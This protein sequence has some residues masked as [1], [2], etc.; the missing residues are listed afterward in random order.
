M[1]PCPTASAARHDDRDGPRQRLERERGQSALGDKTVWTEVDE[2]SVPFV[3]CVGTAV[4]D[5]DVLTFD[6]PVIPQPSA[7]RRSISL[8][9]PP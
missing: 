2:L 5:S 9:R 8:W 6:V 7:S 4:L 1:M 3:A